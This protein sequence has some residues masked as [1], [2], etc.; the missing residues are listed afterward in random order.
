MIASS[1]PTTIRHRIRQMGGTALAAGTLVAGRYRLGDRL[2]AGATG[3]VYAADHVPSG[4][5]MALKVLRADSTR[6]ESIVRRFQREAKAASILDHDNIVEVLDLGR[7]D[8]GRLYLAMER[9]QGEPLS[10]LID[11]RAVGPRRALII[12][13]QALAALAHAH[14]QGVVHRDLKPDNL[15]V[16]RAG[17]P[18]RQYDVVKVLDFG[19]VKL[20]DGAAHVDG[21]RLSATGLVFGTP[22]YLSPEQ[23]LGGDVDARTD[24]Y[25]LGA[26]LLEMLTGAPPFHDDD[27]LVLLRRQATEPAP[28]LAER[29]SGPWCTAAMQ[30]LVDGALQ[31]APA[32]RFLDAAAMTA[33]VDA[34]FASID[35]LPAEVP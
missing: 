10:A 14:E 34:A 17:E 19:L 4:R 35:H 2:G 5:P 11:A 20:L 33:A 29:A 9:V 22:G 8:D 26:V 13:R 1:G 25:A 7:L 28:R 12:C 15:M 23:A 32:D 31:R 21:G 24:L 27:P 6:V 18:G 16:V 3:E 30:A